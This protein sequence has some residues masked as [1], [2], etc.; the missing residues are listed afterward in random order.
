LKSLNDED[1]L[2]VWEVLRKNKFLF[3]FQYGSLMW[4]LPTCIFGLLFTTL[5]WEDMPLTIAR[6]VIGLVV[7]VLTGFLMG[8]FMFSKNERR[9][10]E[11]NSNN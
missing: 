5:L 10:S 7:F 4:G 2:K 6:M 9:F 3:A 1:F 11:L 8:L